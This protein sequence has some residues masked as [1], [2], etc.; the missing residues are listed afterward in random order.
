FHKLTADEYMTITVENH[1]SRVVILSRVHAALTGLSIRRN[2]SEAGGGAIR[3]D[4]SR[5]HRG[6]AMTDGWPNVVPVAPPRSLQ[7]ATPRDKI[8]TIEEL[9]AI[10]HKLRSAGKIVVQAH[11]TFD[12]LHLGHVRHLEA[13]RAQGDVLIVTVTADT[14]VNKGPGRPVFAA[15]MRA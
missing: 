3:H 2:G 10:A 5:F 15:E 7:A 14:F 6:Q 9:A 12:L 1:A 8:R 13:A 4:E 11:G